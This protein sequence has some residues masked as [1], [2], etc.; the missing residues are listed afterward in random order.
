MASKSANLGEHKA[1][2]SCDGKSGPWKE[3]IKVERFTD[4]KLHRDVNF[5]EDVGIQIDRSFSSREQL[6]DAAAKNSNMKWKLRQATTEGLRAREVHRVLPS[7][8][9]KGW[10]DELDELRLDELKV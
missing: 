4:G 1:R 10:K 6:Q 8:A 9:L 5:L 3:L 7:V 2:T